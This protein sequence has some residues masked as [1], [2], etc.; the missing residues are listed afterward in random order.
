[1]LI[2]NNELGCHFAHAIR[3]SA[4]WVEKHKKSNHDLN[5]HFDDNIYRDPYPSSRKKSSS[6]RAIDLP[7]TNFYKM[8]PTELP[9]I[10]VADETT[11]PNVVNQLP[12]RR[13]LYNYENETDTETSAKRNRH[14]V[15]SGGRK[16][17]LQ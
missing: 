17:N 10:D 13:Y 12:M 2:I 7:Q 14:L 6:G 4:A 11:P 5:A 15:K 8:T 3:T 1:M 16:P 9:I